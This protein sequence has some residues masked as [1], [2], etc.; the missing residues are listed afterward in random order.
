MTPIIKDYNKPPEKFTSNKR[1]Q[2]IVKQIL[3]DKNGKAISAYY[4]RAY[5]IEELEIIYHKKCAYCE[6]KPSVTSP[7]EIE[8]YRPK[9]RIEKTSHRGYYWLA[10]EWSNLL[11]ACRKCNQH[12]S[13]KFPLVDENMRCTDD[14]INI[15]DSKALLSEKPLILNP[16]QKSFCPQ[17]HFICRPDGS[18]KGISKYGK[19]TIEIFKLSDINERDEL[20]IARKQIVDKIIAQINTQLWLFKKKYLKLEGLHDYLKNEIFFK[21]LKNA[22]SPSSSYRFMYWMTYKK[23]D[24]FVIQPLSSRI[25]K[26]YSNIVAESFERFIQNRL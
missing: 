9:N 17:I 4:Y 8:H 20:I 25:A 14:K 24:L 15:A 21:L 3:R 10:Y 7:L 26:E 22:N 12:K 19:A 16:E 13:N 5:V 23:F 11:L 2:E 6:S 1:I 18:M